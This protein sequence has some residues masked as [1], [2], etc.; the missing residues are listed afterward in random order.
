[1]T[2]PSI[3]IKASAEVG[4]GPFWIPG[5]NIVH[6]VD[7]PPG[8]I[9]TTDYDTGHTEKFVYKEMV[10]AAVPRSRGGMLA[11]VESGFVGFNRDWGVTHTLD[12]LGDNYRMNDAKTDA[13]G[14]FWAGSN[15]I[16]FIPG[17][18]SLWRLDENWNATV[19]HTGLTLPNGIGWSPDNTVMYVV[20]SM[21]KVILK[22]PFDPDTSIIAGEPEVFAGPEVFNGLPDG[23][24]M[25]TRGHIWLAE[26]GSG[27]LMEFSPDGTI[28][29]RIAIPTEQTTS[30]AF[31][32]PQL[33]KLW[34]T[35]A[36]IGLDPATDPHAGSIFEI[37]GLPAPGIPVVPFAG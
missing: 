11:A 22:F 17:E 37:T 7:I 14:L 1:M 33:D 28:V 2:T 13:S 12:L 3:A 5:D 29:S 26:F 35:S 15:T 8:H 24:A 19:V 27:Q 9:L 25:D 18:G 4:E 30:C 6:W 20:D 31:V 23:L 16:D 32:G 36:A 10:G 34:V 21:Q